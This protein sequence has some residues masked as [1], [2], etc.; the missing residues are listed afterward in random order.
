[1]RNH[2]SQTRANR[3]A[4][5]DGLGARMDRLSDGAGW[6]L[7]RLDMQAPVQKEFDKLCR[8]QSG[9]VQSRMRVPLA[10][11]ERQTRSVRRWDKRHAKRMSLV[12]F[13]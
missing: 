13:H 11:M 9:H 1:M 2:K 7:H 10:V 8:E 3:L 5:Y 12:R 4:H 6:P